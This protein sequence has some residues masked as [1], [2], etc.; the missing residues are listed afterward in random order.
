MR[1]D[2]QWLSYSSD[3]P[4]YLPPDLQDK[5]NE[6]DEDEKKKPGPPLYICTCRNDPQ[7]NSRHPHPSGATVYMN[8]TSQTPCR[9]CGHVG[10]LQRVNQ[11]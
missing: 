11:A 8:Y 4:E 7:C 1:S 5:G 3:E 2:Q 6:E 10:T 9:F